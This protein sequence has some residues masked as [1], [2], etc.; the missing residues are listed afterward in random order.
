MSGYPSGL[1]ASAVEV[2]LR[3]F[4]TTVDV[5]TEPD[6]YAKARMELIV[7]GLLELRGDGPEVYYLTERGEVMARHIMETPLPVHI[8]QMPA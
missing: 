7:V 5:D 1:T 3:Y 4:Y 2:L 8:W 6:Y